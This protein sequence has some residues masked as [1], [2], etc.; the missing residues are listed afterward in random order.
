VPLDDEIIRRLGYCLLPA[1]RDYA[2]SRQPFVDYV[3][4]GMGSH[5]LHSYGGAGSET[6]AACRGLAPWQERC[7]KELMQAHLR[8]GMSLVELS[9]AC[10]LSPSAFARAFKQSTGVTPYQWFLS[11]RIEL[12]MALMSDT[13]HPLS[14][15]A[16]LSGFA[17]QSHFTR[18]FTE[19]VGISPGAWRRGRIRAPA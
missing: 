2:P 19:K 14:D 6:F 7:A 10:R 11:R 9:K 5:L 1:I 12:A 8:E 3:L 15:V 13:D 18:V 4:M 17:D 16:L